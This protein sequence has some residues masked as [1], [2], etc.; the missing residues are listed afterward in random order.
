MLALEARI[1]TLQGRVNA[2]EGM[3][4]MFAGIVIANTGNDPDGSKTATILEMLRAVVRNRIVET[5]SDDCRA[6]TEKAVDQLATL[7]R[8]SIPS[9]RSGFRHDA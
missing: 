8:E 6:E 7:L 2:L 1:K 4:M 9:L 3:C 5:H